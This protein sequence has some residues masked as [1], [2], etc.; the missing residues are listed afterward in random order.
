LTRKYGVIVLK[1][2]GMYMSASMGRVGNDA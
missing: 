1:P 2:G